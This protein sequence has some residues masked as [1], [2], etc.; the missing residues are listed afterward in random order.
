MAGLPPE[1]QGNRAATDSA[2][3]S[4]SSSN[5]QPRTLDQN[6]AIREMLAKALPALQGL[7]SKSGQKPSMM[8]NENNQVVNEEGLPFFEPMEPVPDSP[9]LNPLNRLKHK[10]DQQGRTPGI[11]L[12]FARSQDER[13]RSREQRRA[14]MDDIFGKL[15]QEER[16]TTEQDDEQQEQAQ[17][18]PATST[19]TSED[20]IQPRSPTS[21][22][23]VVL[24]QPT[25]SPPDSPQRSSHPL[26]DISSASRPPPAKSALKQ[27]RPPFQQRPSFGSSG[28]RRG[29][30]NL[31]PSSPDA[32]RSNFCTDDL[33]KDDRERLGR[34]PLAITPVSTTANSS[35]T[36]TPTRKMVRIKSPERFR[37]PLAHAN[38]EQD[39]ADRSSMAG[40]LS[41]LQQALKQTTSVSEKNFSPQARSGG[42]ERHADDVGVEEEAARIIDLLGPDLVEGHPNAPS[43]QVLA[44][45]QREFEA[46]KH[47]QTAPAIAE[48]ARLQEQEREREAERQ[49]ELAAKPA[50]GESVVE[51]SSSSSSSGKTAAFKPGFLN[52][53]PPSFKPVKPPSRAPPTK[54]LGMSALDRAGLSDDDLAQRREKMGL[55]PA[56]PH[57]RPSKAFQEKMDRQRNGQPTSSAASALPDHEELA[58]P[59]GD[60]DLPAEGR[61]RFAAAG[62]DGDDV[63]EPEAEAEAEADDQ[64]DEQHII[65]GEGA[66]ADS[67]EDEDDDDD[68][69]DDDEGY[70]TDDLMD[71]APD[72][73]IDLDEAFD[74]AE[75]MREYARAKAGLENLGLNARNIEEEDD[76]EVDM[77]G[78]EVSLDLIPNAHLIQNART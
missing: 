72:M 30:L 55:N 59:T 63:E 37:T 34:S 50:L 17:N 62:D 67:D 24:R 15:E 56:V 27:G 77:D 45:M 41:A 52:Q 42:V 60:D 44:E 68:D 38:S 35:G 33:E 5:S 11:L 18:Q 69:D 54:S 64:D 28:L 75:L 61:V 16:N 66:D 70:D 29:F 21:E 31:N 9:P 57:A 7:D 1:G 53:K 26:P 3:S 25:P 4:S 32:I 40:S 20:P 47:A 65:H 51:R 23:R 73:D 74:N 48:R 78:G 46:S 19:S 13:E 8:L 71:L 10:P 22:N 14:W 49:R 36:S 2:S 43:K 39:R 58:R 6:A 76:G 12:P